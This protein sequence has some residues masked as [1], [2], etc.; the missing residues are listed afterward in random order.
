MAIKKLSRPFQT[1]DHA[2][3]TYREIMMLKHVDHENV[4][5]RAQIWD[6]QDSISKRDYF[7][8]SLEQAPSFYD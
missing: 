6:I 2:K 3:R 7:W 1:A 8:R 4:S 5:S